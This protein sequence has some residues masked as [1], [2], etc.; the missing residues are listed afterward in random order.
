MHNGWEEGHWTFQFKKYLFIKSPNGSGKSFDSATTTNEI[1]EL[2]VVVQ[3]ANYVPSGK[4]R[5]R[6]AFNQRRVLFAADNLCGSSFNEPLSCRRVMAVCLP[7]C[8]SRFDCTPAAA[9]GSVLAIHPSN[10]FDCLH[11]RQLPLNSSQSFRLM[12]AQ[13]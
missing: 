13:W 5:E 9:T 4:L 12:K 8:L 1:Y 11:T 10:L 6:Y 7:V 3:I 2:P